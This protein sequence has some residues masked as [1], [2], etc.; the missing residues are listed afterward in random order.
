MV[1]KLNSNYVILPKF[2]TQVKDFLG[3][4]GEKHP[5]YIRFFLKKCI[6]DQF[7]T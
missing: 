2:N 3:F 6:I 7:L 5:G 4:K 1:C